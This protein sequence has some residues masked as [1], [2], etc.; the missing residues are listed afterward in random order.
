MSDLFGPE[1]DEEIEDEEIDRIMRDAAPGIEIE[2]AKER[3]QWLEEHLGDE[4]DKDHGYVGRDDVL[5]DLA[6]VWTHDKAGWLRLEPILRGHKVLA[7]IK[8][9]VKRRAS[10]TNRLRVVSGAGRQL[11]SEVLDDVP[12]PDEAEIPT[13][14]MIRRHAPMGDARLLKRVIK[15]QGDTHTEELIGVATDHIFVTSLL[16]DVDTGETHLDVAYKAGK[17]WQHRVV[18][19]EV[20]AS[21]RNAALALTGYGFP[22]N[23]NNAQDM[24][25]WLIDFEA[26]NVALLPRRRITRQMGWQSGKRAKQAIESGLIEDD[27]TEPPSS[28]FV[29][30]DTHLRDEDEVEI[31]FQGADVGDQHLVRCL[32]SAG[33]FEAWAEGV[34]VFARRYPDIELAVYAGLAPPILEILQAGNFVVEWSGKTS[35]GKTTA[36]MM[37]ASLWG[38]PDDKH[39]DSFIASWDNTQVYFERRSANLNGLPMILDDTKRAR[40]Y[41]GQSIVPPT[42]FAIANGQGRGRGSIKGTQAIR[43]WRTVLLSTGEYRCIDFDKSGGTAARVITLWGQALG[44]KC[45]ETAD[46]LREVKAVLFANHGHAGKMW[47]EWLRAHQADWPEWRKRLAAITVKL[48]R[49]VLGAEQRPNDVSVADRLAGNLAVLELVGELAHEALDL[50]WEHG[51]PALALVDKAA[52]GA[53]VADREVEAL[54][55]LASHLSS[56][57]QA[58]ENTDNDAK[59]PLQGWLGWTGEHD[60]AQV[61]AVY[62]EKLRKLLTDWGFEPLSILRRWREEGIIKCRPGRTTERPTVTSGARPRLVMFPC[63]EGIRDAGFDPEGITKDDDDDDPAIKEPPLPTDRDEPPTPT[64]RDEPPTQDDFF[65]Q[66]NGEPF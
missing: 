38:Q 31:H 35:T 59:P 54:K 21:A 51:Y 3:G 37:A 24:I 27:T 10:A 36:V 62:P 48:R 39:R 49:A 22:I 46:T 61:V 45:E 20:L 28:S 64:D 6:A 18:P 9:E 13:G 12:L 8:A 30:G 53:Q 11:V 17:H 29:V 43:Y 50:P 44:A 1:N 2:T 25:Q 19:R 15:K 26:L 66:D 23:A 5:A 14:W 56:N 41:Q 57:P 47:I 60:K 63:D 34:A 52:A 16:T 42:I 58:I 33:T 4:L 7:L 40:N 55:L 65:P 32:Q